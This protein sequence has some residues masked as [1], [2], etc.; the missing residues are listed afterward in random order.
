MNWRYALA[1]RMLKPIKVEDESGTRWLVFEPDP[2]W[3]LVYALKG[4]GVEYIVLTRRTLTTGILGPTPS[5]PST[6]PTVDIS[7][8]RMAQYLQR[9]VRLRD[10]HQWCATE[11]ADAQMVE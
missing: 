9:V 2:G 4:R 3:P 11:V 6:L 7:N 8:P 5:V 1:V 10:C